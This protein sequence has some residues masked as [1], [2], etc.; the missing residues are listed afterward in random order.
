MEEVCVSGKMTSAVNQICL[1]FL[2]DVNVRERWAD[3]K[4]QEMHEKH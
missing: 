1:N 4:C 2:F 3:L